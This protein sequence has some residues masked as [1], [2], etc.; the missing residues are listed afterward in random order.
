MSTS[1]EV[2]RCPGDCPDPEDVRV[3]R[4]PGHNPDPSETN[5]L[6]VNP[7]NR[8]VWQISGSDTQ[9]GNLWARQD[10]GTFDVL[11]STRDLDRQRDDIVQDLQAD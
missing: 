7:V 4:T 9:L 6:T 11:S 5:V 3:I 1:G 8:N 2:L 10:S